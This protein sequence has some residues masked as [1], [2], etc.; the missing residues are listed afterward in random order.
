MTTPNRAFE[1]YLQ[2]FKEHSHM[3]R[4]HNQ[5][6]QDM[7]KAAIKEDPNFA[8]ALGHL[9]YTRL[10]AW[11][12][13][14]DTSPTPPDDLR[15]QAAQAS[16]LDPDDYDNVWSQAGVYFYTAKY[17]SRRTAAFRAGLALFDNAIDMARTAENAIG[18]NIDGLLVDKADALFFMARTGENVDEAIQIIAD[19][20]SRIGDNHPSRF[21]WS[22]G[23]AHYERAAFRDDPSE[24]EADLMRSLEAL[25]RINNPDGAVQKNLIAT[26]G[27][28]G[29][30]KP[31]CR[32]AAEF[33]GRHPNYTVAIEDR[34]PYAESRRLNRWKGHLVKA[35]LPSG[36]KSSARRRR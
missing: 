19:A 24:A 2:G 23:W 11:L 27:A 21:L 5:L 8:R 7:F 31:A 36:N 4:R 17:Q 13:G 34:W 25:L 10:I 26:Y 20:V 29:W 1:Y 22:L 15:D 6:A 35:G 9:A 30:W 3:T 14:W 18:H 32:V 12:N 28:L 16:D 33:R